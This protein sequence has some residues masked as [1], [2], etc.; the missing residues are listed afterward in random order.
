MNMKTGWGKKIERTYARNRKN[1]W[2]ETNEDETEK[3]KYCKIKY[4][5]LKMII[6]LSF[7]FLLTRIEKMKFAF[8]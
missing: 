4:N 5:V 1:H 8:V 3:K 2:I 6:S 7:S